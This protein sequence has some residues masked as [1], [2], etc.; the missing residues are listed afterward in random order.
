MT[1]VY[2]RPKIFGEYIANNKTTIRQTAKH[3]GISK[4]TV[5]L[6]VSKKLKEIDF[7]L[8]KKV[9]KVLLKNFEERNLRGGLA[10]KQKYEKLKKDAL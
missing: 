8:Y 4:S 2:L 6:D 10:T 7:E 5:H 1:G 3:F 9:K